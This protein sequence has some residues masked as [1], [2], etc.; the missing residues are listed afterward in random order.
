MNKIVKQGRNKLVREV[1]WRSGDG[2]WVVV[3]GPFPQAFPRSETRDSVKKAALQPYLDVVT[4]PET[5]REDAYA[6][7]SA[8]DVI[9]VQG[10]ANE[11][12]PVSP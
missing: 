11:F 9:E 4:R 5:T 10:G 7:V 6:K 8:M 1:K 2:R 3:S 12:G